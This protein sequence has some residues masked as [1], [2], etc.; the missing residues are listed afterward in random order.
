MTTKKILKP[1]RE[2]DAI[3]IFEDTFREVKFEY[4]LWFNEMLIRHSVYS[5]TSKNVYSKKAI[6]VFCSRKLERWVSSRFQVEWAT[7]DQSGAER[8]LSTDYE[9]GLE[10]FPL[11]EKIEQAYKNWL[12]DKAIEK[13]L[14]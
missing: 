1:K 7:T 14:T 3:V 4:Q 11:E 9:F 8:S 13:V 6:A 12:A 2:P 10:D 5:K